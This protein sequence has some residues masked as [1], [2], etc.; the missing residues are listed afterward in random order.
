MC[1]HC[2]SEQLGNSSNFSPRETNKLLDIYDPI[3]ASNVKCYP[4]DASEEDILRWLR[5]PGGVGRSRRLQ[6]LIWEWSK[7]KSDAANVPL[8]ISCDMLE[9]IREAWYFPHELLQMLLSTMPLATQLVMDVGHGLFLRS[10]RSRDWSFCLTLMY[11]R[12]SGT[13]SGLIYGLRSGELERLLLRLHGSCNALKDPILL[14]L[15][16]LERKVYFFG[17]LLENRARGL[18]EIEESTGMVHGFD[19][20]RERE[21]ERPE[22][23]LK[24]NF[25]P[26][27]QKLTGIAGTLAFCKMTFESSLEGL[28]VASTWRGQILKT[29]R[30]PDRIGLRWTAAPDINRRI[31]YLRKFISGALQQ[32]QVLDARRAAQVQTVYSMISQRDSEIMKEM[33]LLAQRDS[34]DMRII[35]WVTLIFLPG[36]FTAT[37]FS[38]SFFDFRLGNKEHIVSWWFWLYCLFTAIMTIL[39]LL[40]WYYFYRRSNRRINGLDA[41]HFKLER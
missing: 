20:R 13:I 23:S 11:S 31:S 26:I 33:T 10:A 7:P 24:I 21:M 35:A 14:P 32:V 2:Y 37:L 3:S 22:K 17:S 40:V 38:T 15:L 6:I 34:K 39:I 8:P 29:S 30:E 41:A 27:I 36:T 19:E 5:R 28:N 4:K 18:E 1:D 16:L 9:A 25:D 12:E